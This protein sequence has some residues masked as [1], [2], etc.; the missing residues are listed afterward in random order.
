MELIIPHPHIKER[1]FVLKP[2][3]D[4]DSKH[5][6]VATNKKISD[7]LMETSDS[8]KLLRVKK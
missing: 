4:I 5:V 8:S 7:L 2:W 3:A 1:K 6:L